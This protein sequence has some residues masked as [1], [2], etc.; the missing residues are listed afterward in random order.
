MISIQE[1]PEIDYSDPAYE[2][3]PFHWLAERAKDHKIARSSRGVEILDYDL[4]RKFLLDRNL[5]TDHGNLIEKMGLPESRALEFKRRMLL[6]QN[7]GETR[8]RLRLALT[9]LIGPKQA[10]SMRQDIST[11]VSE[12]IE[13]L[14][15]GGTELK[16]NFTDLVPAG[17]Y[18]SWVDAPL[19]DARFVS[20]MSQTVLSIF[21]R[22][23]SLTPKIVSAYDK[24][25]DYAKLRLQERRESPRDDFLSRL[26][27]I[28]EAGD[29]SEDELEDFAVM[30]IEASTDNTSHQLSIAIDRLTQ[31]P[32]IW[33]ALGKDPSLIQPAIR[34]TMRLWPRSISTSRTA[35]VDTV[36][37]DVE[38]PSGTSIFGSFGAAH[39]QGDIYDDPHEFKIDRDANPPHMN[40]GGGVFSC[41]GQFVA[42]IELEEA[43]VQLARRFPK[44]KVNRSE[45]GFSAMFQT[46]QELD[47]TY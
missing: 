46:V 14:P 24:L 18:C 2:A 31:M 21:S 30:L 47:V 36:I 17:V 33:S 44:L 34:E 9:G 13:K 27:Q 23:P 1:L 15:S 28:S 29:L 3:E 19:S 45:R 39:R 40:F 38:I 37:E 4:C 11:V 12:L 16:Y 25:F 26:I 32:E 22:D 10:E 42:T 20:E 35:L 6:T 43:I 7:R 41:L 5:G 8:Q